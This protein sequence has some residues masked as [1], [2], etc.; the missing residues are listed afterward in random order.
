MC[1]FSVGAASADG[2]VLAEADA[3]SILEELLPAQNKAYLLGLKFKLESYVVESIHKSYSEPQ[4]HLLH[5]ILE[6]LKQENPKP[7]WR[8]I[9]DA[10]KSPAVNLPQLAKKIEENHFP[11][12]TSVNVPVTSGKI[13]HTIHL[14]TVSC[15]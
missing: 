4:M 7:S 12:S 5:V 11:G 6:F 2:G 14:Y 3:F 13:L 15:V 10:L 1:L 9:V 8:A